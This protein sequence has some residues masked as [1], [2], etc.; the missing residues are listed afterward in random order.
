MIDTIPNR[1]VD[2]DALGPV[3]RLVILAGGTTGLRQSELLGL[4]WRDID[5]RA[6][7]VRVRN[8]WVRYEHPGEG[9][10]LFGVGDERVQGA[11]HRRGVSAEVSVVTLRRLESPGED[12]RG[13]AEWRLVE[14]HAVANG[15]RDPVL[16]GARR[17]SSRGLRP[18]R[19]G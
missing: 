1:T 10:L 15:A 11:C 2:R 9:N 12:R 7:H 13:S 6:Q 18:A 19:R 14:G 8:A 16:A 4:R 5:L 3:L 17:D